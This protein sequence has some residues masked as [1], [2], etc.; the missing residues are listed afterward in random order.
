MPRYS[1]RLRRTLDIA[2]SAVI[3]VAAVPVIVLV[4]IAIALLMGRPVLFR[5]TRI[6]CSE[7]PFDLYKFRTMR[8]SDG[9]GRPASDAERLGPFGNWLRSTSLDELPQLWN[10]LKGDMSLVGPRPLLPQYL[11][12]YTTV[13]RRRHEVRPGITGWAQVNGR[14]A[15]SWEDKFRLDVWYVDRRSLRLDCTILWLT[16]KAVLT[17]RG[18]AA[19]GHVTV[20]EFLGSIAQ[21]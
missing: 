4:A 6:G 1:D 5:Q 16:L 10:V 14:N 17:R 11:D 19:N 21:E 18:V 2:I 12:R 3:L 7:R 15:I 9:S 20:P 13:Q 8:T